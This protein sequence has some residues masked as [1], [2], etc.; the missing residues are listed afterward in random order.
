MRKVK[1]W[2]YYCEFCK[3]KSGGSEGHMARHE[4]SCTMNPDR[5]CKMCKYGE[6]AQPSI[7]DMLEALKIALITKEIEKFKI[8]NDLFESETYKIENE[9]EAVEKLREIANGCPMCML[10]AIRQTGYPAPLFSSFDFK[11]EKEIFWTEFR[12]S[13]PIDYE[14]EIGY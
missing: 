14:R 10:A 7:I 3:K 12:D 1:R 8:D 9:K 13:E 5:I 2:R 6:D 11:K 4:K